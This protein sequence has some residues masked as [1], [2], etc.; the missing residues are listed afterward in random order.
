MVR[1]TWEEMTNAE[2]QS[3]A[4]ARRALFSD[5]RVKLD[6]PWPPSLNHYWRHVRNTGRTL[7]SEEGRS[8]RKRVAEVVT[9]DQRHRFG[10]GPVAIH[11][12]AYPPDRRRRDLDNMLKAV[13]DALAHTHVYS[14][15]S[16]IDDLHIL[17]GGRVGGGLLVVRVERA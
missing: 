17:R 13:L 15:D 4:E 11:I 2:R 9:R 3:D 10:S 1:K 7:I 16:Q 14:D 6:L 5:G 12:V 8:Y